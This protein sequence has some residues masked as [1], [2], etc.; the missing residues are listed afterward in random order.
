M[1]DFL[2][3]VLLRPVD[4]GAFGSSYPPNLFYAPKFCWAQKNVF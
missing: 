4:K 2:A 3:T 1:E